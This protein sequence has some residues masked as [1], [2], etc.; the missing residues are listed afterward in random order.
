MTALQDLWKGATDSAGEVWSKMPTGMKIALGAGGGLLAAKALVPKNLLLSSALLRAGRE[1]SDD[2][3]LSAAGF[4][5]DDLSMRPGGLFGDDDGQGVPGTDDSVPT[6][7]FPLEESLMAF[8]LGNAI[9]QR[10]V[11][12]PWDNMA[13]LTGD[14]S[15]DVRVP[16]IFISHTGDLVPDPRLYVWAL[17]NVMQGG[18]FQKIGTALKK[19]AAKALPVTSKVASFIPGAGPVVSKIA[20]AGSN[21]LNAANAAKAKAKDDAVKS[22]GAASMLSVLESGDRAEDVQSVAIPTPAIAASSSSFG[23]NPPLPPER[24]FFSTEEVDPALREAISA[25]TSL[26]GADRDILPSEFYPTGTG[27]TDPRSDIG[28]DVL[29]GFIPVLLAAGKWIGTI[30]SL[31][32]PWIKRVVLNRAFIKSIGSKFAS[33]GKVAGTSAGTVFKFVGP[34]AL[35][36]ASTIFYFIRKG[37]AKQQEELAA[38]VSR[39]LEG[40]EKD[41]WTRIYEHDIAK[42]LTVFSKKE[43]EEAAQLVATAVLTCAGQASLP[44]ANP[45]VK[46]DYA[47]I[48]DTVDA[49]KKENPRAYSDLEKLID[50]AVAEVHAQLGGGSAAAEAAT[51]ASGNGSVPY[52]A[53]SSA[54]GALLDADEVP[55]DAGG[56]DDFSSPE[57]SEVNDDSGDSQLKDALLKIGVPAAMVTGIIALIKSQVASKNADSELPVTADV[58]RRAYI[59]IQL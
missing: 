8:E 59:P 27:L 26:P 29:L 10:S 6:L 56:L 35:L 11:I 21:L 24:S 46:K 13:V 12:S 37:E 54:S 36:G 45:T 20:A 22:K 14:P 5:G 17:P 58:Q 7:L 28:S 9:R 2:D 57:G 1:D 50:G 4:I 38:A 31:A 47:V 3:R 33:I 43:Q 44:N 39:Y 18:L 34:K 42:R 16:A 40:E 48:L 55:S 53:A 41:R 15:K 49:M 19:V 51:F 32:W 23:L 25:S 30:G 52:E